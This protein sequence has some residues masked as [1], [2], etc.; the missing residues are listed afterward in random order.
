LKIVPLRGNVDTRLRK[1]Q[2]GEFDAVILAA[3]GVT[4]LGLAGSVRHYFEPDVMCPA[5]GQGALAIEA[6]TD[7]SQTISCLRFLDHP[8][9]RAAVECERA[10]LNALGGGCQVP[11]GAYADAAGEGLLLRVVVASPD[12]TQ[13][14]RDRR[15]GPDPKELGAQAGDALLARGAQQILDAVYGQQTPVPQQP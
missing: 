12:G 6:R 3:A 4:R 2:L 14:I 13:I 15:S 7:D 5:A 8:P 1:L 9:T 10:A 11:I